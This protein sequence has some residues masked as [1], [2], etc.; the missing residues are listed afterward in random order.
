MSIVFVE[1]SSDSSYIETVTHGF[2]DGEGSTIRPAEAHWHLV[3]TRVRDNFFPILVGPLS[4]A[5]VVHFGAGAEVLWIKFR[6]GTFMPHL[7]LR[8]F[9]DIETTLPEASRQSFWLKGSAWPFPDYQ[10][11]ETFASRLVKAGVLALDPEVSQALQ[12]RTPDLSPRTVRH[13]F[14]QATGLTHSHIYQIERAK[15]AAAILEQGVSILDAV[16]ELGYYDQPH[17]TRSL[18]AWIGHTPAQL[19]R[20]PAPA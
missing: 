5:G 4:R 7:P 8:Q 12:G 20:A 19:A 15:R 13:R 17:L 10:N 2:I 6:L 9:R 16:E 14:L 1:R 18:K 11:T 3:F